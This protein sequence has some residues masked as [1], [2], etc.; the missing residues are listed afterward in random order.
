MPGGN[1]TGPMGM[2]PMTGRGAGYC[3][4]L[5]TSGYADPALGRGFARGRGGRGGRSAGQGFGRSMGFRWMNPYIS[6]SAL[7]SQEEAKLLKTQAS[8]MQS[9]INSINARIKELELGEAQQ[10]DNG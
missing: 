10:G 7:S 4:G 5:P 1:G 3:A 8:S 6:G 9:E 2:G